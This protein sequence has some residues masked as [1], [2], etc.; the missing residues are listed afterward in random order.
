MSEEVNVKAGWLTPLLH[1]ADIETSIRFYE[2]PGFT[3]IDTDRGK[4]VGWARLHC[5]GGALMFL[6]AEEADSR[7][8]P[9]S[10]DR[11]DSLYAGHGGPLCGD[12]GEAPRFAC[13]CD[14]PGERCA[15]WC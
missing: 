12:S 1:A 5:E 14:S 2:L 8:F 13:R 4:P 15:S 3:T 11:T 7:S 6:R 10:S 9:L